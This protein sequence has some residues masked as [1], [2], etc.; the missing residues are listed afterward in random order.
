MEAFTGE[1]K[2][3]R[4]ATGYEIKR[5][6]TIPAAGSPATRAE[7]PGTFRISDPQIP[8]TKLFF[9]WEVWLALVTKA[10]RLSAR[11]AYCA[12]IHQRCRSGEKR[13]RHLR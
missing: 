7:L 3:V 4:K 11:V 8:L 5:R 13:D 10:V 12:P 1:G 9:E 2:L 6:P